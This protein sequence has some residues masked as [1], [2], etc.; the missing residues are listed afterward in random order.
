M[1]V[2]KSVIRFKGNN[3]K[4]VSNV[5]KASY[6]IAE[7]SRAALRD[8]GK[9]VT[10]ISNSSAQKLHG[11]RKSRRVF[12]RKSAFQYWARKRESDLQVGIK[13]DTWYGVD[14][15]LGTN[16]QPKLGILRNSTYNNIATII[17]IESK[18][19]SALEDEAAAL[20]KIS[21]EEYTGSGDE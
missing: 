14:Q 4:Y 20:A 15:E 18:Y 6:L 5:D 10:R 16:K 13:H 8:V 12:G 21:E 17:E 11:L 9:Y 19:L 2:P 3:V 7:L 1:S